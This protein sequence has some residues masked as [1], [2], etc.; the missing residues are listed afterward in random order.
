MDP[1]NISPREFLLYGV[2]INTGVGFVLG[3]I[4]LICGIIKGKARNGILGLVC[5]TIGGAILGI[6]LAIPAAAISTWLILRDPKVADAA[7]V[8]NDDGP[9][10][11]NVR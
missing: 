1:N 7:V 3:L 4:P 6:V 2:L 8:L 9:G 10:S 11:S 5:S